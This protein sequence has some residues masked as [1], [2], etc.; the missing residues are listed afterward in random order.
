MEDRGGDSIHLKWDITL[1]DEASDCHIAVKYCRPG[2]SCS[3]KMILDM[4]EESTQL[5]VEPFHI[6]NITMNTTCAFGPDMSVSETLNVSRSATARKFHSFVP[7]QKMLASPSRI[8]VLHDPSLQFQALLEVLA[9]FIRAA[10]SYSG[11][12]RPMGESTCSAIRSTP[13]HRLP[14]N[15]MFR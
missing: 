15:K 6:Y 1:L 3:T 5:E 7:D 2:K 13:R 4:T 10:G 9:S 12:P 11:K 14:G 8:V